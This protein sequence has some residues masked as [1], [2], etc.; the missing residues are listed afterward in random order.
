[1]FLKAGCIACH[2]VTPDEPP[3]GP[4][5]SAVAKIYDR[6]ALTESILKPSAKI[7]QGFETTF[8]KTKKGEQI[9]GFVTREG[10]DSVDV[11][12]IASQTLTIEKADIAERGT[13]P[14]S[15]MPEG[16]LNAFTTADLANLLAWL[17]SL[18]K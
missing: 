15:M 16:L 13:R 18:K 7:A 11:R 8:F 2:T 14:Q 6:A 10:G 4:L 17:E 1:M 9:E 12:N 3:K 5:L